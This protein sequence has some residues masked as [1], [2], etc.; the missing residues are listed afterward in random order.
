MMVNE[1]DRHKGYYYRLSGQGFRAG[2]E[3]GVVYHVP[4]VAG[5]VC[6]AGVGRIQ[7][8]VDAGEGVLEGRRVIF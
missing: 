2:F 1:P 4:V 8:F 6:S 3:R 7:G 5:T